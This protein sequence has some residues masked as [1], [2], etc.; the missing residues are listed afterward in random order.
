MPT[1]LIRDGILT[2][3]RINMLSPNAELF[4]RRLMSVADDHG[5][6]SGNLTLLR[7]SCYPLKLDSVKEDSIKKHLAECVDAGLIVPYTVAA[8]PYIVMVDFGQRIQAKSKFPE[9]PSGFQDSTVD[10]GEAPEK[11]ALD[12]GVVVVEKEQVGAPPAAPPPADPDAKGDKRAS[13]LPDD[14]TLPA[15][16]ATWA[17]QERPDLNPVDTAARF[18]DHWHAK[19]GK[20]GRKLDWL[21]TWRNWVRNERARPATAPS[22]PSAVPRGKPAG[23]SE[24]PLENAIAFAR[25]RFSIGA[26]DETERD[27]LIA[28]ATAKHRGSPEIRA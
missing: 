16:W 24:T 13:R 19:P 2:S 7:A 21:A 4:Y 10:H 5:R 28:Q 1:R 23:P 25:Q 17:R 6:F 12:G 15:E 8:K 18:A 22:P 20:D 14:W 3:E 27:R 26:I 9:P 11:T